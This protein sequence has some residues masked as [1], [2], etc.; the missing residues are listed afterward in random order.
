M[1]NGSIKSEVSVAV[2][3]RFAKEGIEMPFPQRV[4]HQG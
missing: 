4:T 2:W 1:N 3:E